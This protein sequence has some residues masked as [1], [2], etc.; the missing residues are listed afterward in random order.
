MA[1]KPDLGPLM[2]SARESIG[3]PKTPPPPPP[4]PAESA[5]AAYLRDKLARHRAWLKANGKL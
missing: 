5:D 2:G 1:E 3:A 4:A